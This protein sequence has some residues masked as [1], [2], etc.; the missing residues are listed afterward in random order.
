M[1]DIPGPTGIV[2]AQQVVEYDDFRNR[3][4]ME[5]ELLIML[6]NQMSLMEPTRGFEIR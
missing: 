1:A 3:V 2:N 5:A 4:M 6:Q